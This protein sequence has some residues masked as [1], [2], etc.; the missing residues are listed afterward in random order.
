M[1]KRRTAFIRRRVSG[2]GSIVHIEEEPYVIEQ[3]HNVVG[4]LDKIV[5]RRLRWWERLWRRLGARFRP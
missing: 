5:C 3:I 4:D 2:V 1:G